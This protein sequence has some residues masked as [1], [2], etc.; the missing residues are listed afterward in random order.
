MENKKVGYIILGISAVLILIIFLFQG[1]L[2]DIVALGC[3]EGPS[4]PMFGT[5]H[6]QTSLALIIVGILVVLGGILIFTKP[7]ERIV[8]KK[9]RER[10]KK[11]DKS[12]LGQKE[13]KAIEL[14]ENENGTMFQATLMEKLEIGKVGMTR[15]IDKL[16]AKQLV[17]RKRRG[18]NNVIVLK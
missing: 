7:K 3:Q 2:K 8:V 1:A 15:L 4:C 17:E 9:V 14:L 6:Q 16:E 11:I 12:K 5:I 13:K 18:M 10:K